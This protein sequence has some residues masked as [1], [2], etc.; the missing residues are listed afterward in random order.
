MYIKIYF[1]D[2]PLFLCDEMTDE[3][4][5]YAHHDDAVLIDEYSHPAVNAMIHEMRRES[6]HAGIFLHSDVGTLKKA[7]WKKF[8][9]V[10]AGGG[11]VQNPAGRYLFMLR[12]SKWDLPK[13]KLDPG[14]TLE[15]CAVREVGEETGLSQV[16]LDGP[17]LVTYHTYD[18]NGHHILK[19]THWFR[20]SLLSDQAIVPQQEEQ[21]TELVWADTTKISSLIKNTFPSILDVLYAAGLH[22]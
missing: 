22:V 19:E 11:L 4:K 6:V 7:F 18:E 5:R 20:M 14:E 1:N 9:L 12:R 15:Q 2:K 17:L 10:Q 8:K 16:R 21:I 3:I 13:G